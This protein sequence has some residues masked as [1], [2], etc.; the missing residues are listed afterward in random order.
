MQRAATYFV[1]TPIYYVN[2]EP[3]IGHLFSSCLA[4]SLARYHRLFNRPTLLT[5]GCDEHGQKVE[6]ASIQ[7][8]FQNVQQFCS[9]NSNKFRLLFDSA[10]IDYST[11]GFLRTSE[12]RHVDCVSSVWNRLS[13]SGLLSKASYEG[14]Y[15]TSDECF[16]SADDLVRS[17]DPVAGKEKFVMRETGQPV[18]LCSEVNWLL[19][20]ND[21]KSEVR[22]YLTSGRVV[23]P[24]RYSESALRQLNSTPDTLSVSR[25][26]SRCSWGVPVPGDPSQTVYVWLDA[27]CNYLTCAGYP[28]HLRAWPP[29]DQIVGK[30]I[31][32]FHAIIWPAILIA[33]GLQPPNRI[34]CHGHWLCDG[35][36][37][38]KSL[39]NVVRPDEDLFNRLSRDGLR[40]ALLRSGPVTGEDADFQLAR[41]I[42]TVND[43]LV[44]CM[45]NLASRASS[46][47]IHRRSLPPVESH[48]DL[49]RHAANLNE[50][51]FVEQLL[52]LS[53]SLHS[54]WSEV[55]IHHV[56]DS[57]VSVWRS[58][59]SL[60]DRWHPWQLAKSDDAE[61]MSKLDSLLV[62]VFASLRLTGLHLTPLC[63]TL[64]HRLMSASG[65]D[66]SDTVRFDSPIDSVLLCPRELAAPSAS[67]EHLIERREV[68]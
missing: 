22:K 8:G 56:A 5:T 43:E 23:V 3:H 50:H 28:N 30:D 20:M 49:L 42:H 26:T 31:L 61:S 11:G 44:N 13:S 46:P 40:Y 34:I 37:M 1:T 62:L 17:E 68:L 7:A 47:K 41:S 54:Q 6:Q 45:A 65:V 52:N 19:R 9:T 10:G 21:L 16:V 48:K 2:A 63:P 29:T 38:S 33:M 58:A 64:G 53:D 67:R 12:L 39:G 32:R 18:E 15:S 27:L 25:P 14:W 24:D 59:N 60:F 66:K 4:D 57:L 36:K 35:R 51:Q 55:R